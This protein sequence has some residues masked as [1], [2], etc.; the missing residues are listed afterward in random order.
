MST[1]PSQAID[2]SGIRAAAVALGSV[3]MAAERV[4]ANLPPDQAERI[5]ERI[6]KRAYRERWLADPRRDTAKSAVVQMPKP[7]VQS[8]VQTVQ[9]GAEMLSN[10][11][12]DDKRETTLAAAKFARRAMQDA[13]DAPE[14]LEVARQAKDAFQVAAVLHGIGVT[15]GPTHVQINLLGGA[16]GEKAAQATETEQDTPVIDV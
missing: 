5:R 11:L 10:Q 12:A 3:N 1:A 16:Y 2:W 13:A 14:P 15:T 4:A 7:N 8:L 6:N 9:S